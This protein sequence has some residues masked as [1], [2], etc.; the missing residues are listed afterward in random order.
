MTGMHQPWPR[1]RS[2]LPQQQPP[3]RKKNCHLDKFLSDEKSISLSTCN[4][5]G[6]K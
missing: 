5:K 6:N 3:K 4:S 2:A 1:R